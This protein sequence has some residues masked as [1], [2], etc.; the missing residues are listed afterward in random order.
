[1]M[2]A[3]LRYDDL[4][5]IIDRMDVAQYAK[6]RNFTNGSVSYLSPYISRGIISTK[7]VYERLR[8]RGIHP[9]EMEV[10]LKELLWRD[11]FQRLGQVNVEAWDVDCPADMPSFLEHASSGIH[12]VDEAII[13]LRETGYMHNHLRM[14]LA[15]ITLNV[16]KH[17][18]NGPAKWLYYH[19]LDADFASNTASWLWVA[20]DRGKKKYWVNQENINH[21]TN[22]KQNNS[23]LD[24]SYEELPEAP[25]PK[26]LEAVINLNLI[27]NL[28]QSDTLQVEENK[29]ILIYTPYNLDPN[30]YKGEAFNRILW[31]SPRFFQRWPM[32]EKTMDFLILNARRIEGL[33]VFVGELDELRKNLPHAKL[34]MKEH[35]LFQYPAIVYEE[36][37]WIVPSLKGEFPSFFNYWNK[38]S[39][40]IYADEK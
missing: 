36:R 12:A 34:R 19:L 20:G 4:I 33:Q 37:D 26:H 28:P 24:K 14:Y 9:K 27:T 7:Q 1:M 6:T 15:S 21:Y 35:P 3:Q 8:Q 38:A 13:R 17:P 29:E 18:F 22:S 32:S 30:W 40:L 5:A 31:L 16:A 11:Y 10:F 2:Q 39:K 25:L 23:F